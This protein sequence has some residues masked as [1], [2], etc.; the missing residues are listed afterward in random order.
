MLAKDELGLGRNFKDEH[1]ETK[2]HLKF[3]ARGTAATEDCMESVF[4]P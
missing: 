4:V 3:V 2:S 1:G